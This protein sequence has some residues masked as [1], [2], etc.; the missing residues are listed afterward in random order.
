M[1]D[2]LKHL[3]VDRQ[4]Q[5]LRFITDLP[6]QNLSNKSIRLK[7]FKNSRS[8]C[9][10]IIKYLETNNIIRVERPG[11]TYVNG[12]WVAQTNT[13]TSVGAEKKVD[14]ADV[15]IFEFEN[16]NIV[17]E[18]PKHFEIFNKSIKLT[19]N[20]FGSVWQKAVVEECMISGLSKYQAEFLWSMYEKSKQPI[21]KPDI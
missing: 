3:P 8:F 19:E 11:N 4:N 1:K 15:R 5:T 17:I 10:D 21:D 16:K 18:K 2:L 7:Y 9:D 6:I 13:Y 20:L 12:K 14:V